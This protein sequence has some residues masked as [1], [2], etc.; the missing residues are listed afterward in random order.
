[1]SHVKNKYCYTGFNMLRI[2][3][4]CGNAGDGGEL[5]VLNDREVSLINLDEDDVHSFLFKLGRH[6]DHARTGVTDDCDYGVDDNFYIMLTY[7]KVLSTA[8]DFVYTFTYDGG[9][10]CIRVDFNNEKLAKNFLS[11]CY[12]KK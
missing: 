9:E 3:L 7:S 12:R 4:Y 6:L 11:K 2:K 10:K 8:T 5:E 1:M